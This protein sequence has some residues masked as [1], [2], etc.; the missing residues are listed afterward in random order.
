MSEAK[1]IRNANHLK[2]WNLEIIESH[3]FSKILFSYMDE[4]IKL[5]VIKYNK[6]LQDKIDINL[7]NY[8]FL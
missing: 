7:N 8:K 4:K 1:A 3:F 6:K 5:K 2:N